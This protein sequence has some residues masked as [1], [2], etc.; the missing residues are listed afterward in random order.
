MRR[1]AE[2]AGASASCQLQ[3]VRW[4]GR[5]LGAAEQQRAAGVD[6]G[7]PRSTTHGL[8]AYTLPRFPTER[9]GK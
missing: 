3:Q 5:G 1:A 4:W 6:V 7:K 9:E 8:R 2:A